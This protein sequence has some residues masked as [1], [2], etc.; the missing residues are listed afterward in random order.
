M[1]AV[2]DLIY[3]VEQEIDDN[4]RPLREEG[5]IPSTDEVYSGQDSKP[6]LYANNSFLHNQKGHDLLTA[7]VKQWQLRLDRKFNKVG[8]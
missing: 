1:A 8:L 3:S 5:W 6:S 7:R 4:P 2:K